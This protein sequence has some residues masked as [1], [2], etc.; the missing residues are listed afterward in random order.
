MIKPTSD[1]NSFYQWKNYVSIHADHYTK[2][3]TAPGISWKVLPDHGRTGSAVTT[4]PVTAKAQQPAKL[5]AHLQYDIYVLDTGI[6]TLQAQFSPTLNFHNT[7]NGLQYAI[8][9]D[10]E[11]PQIFSINKN[12][13]NVQQWNEWVANNIINRYS[14]HRITSTGKHVVKYWMI[15]SGVVLQKIVLNF[16]TLKKHYLGPAETKITTR[17]LELR[18]KYSN[19]SSQ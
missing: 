10:N 3:I 11:K 9:I 16:G 6:V 8:S 5:I 1:T 4:Y 14:K 15:N 17:D 19:Q 2:A 7:I 12:D 18:K 13:N